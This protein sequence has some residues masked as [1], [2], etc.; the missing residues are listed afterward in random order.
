MKKTYLQM[1]GLV[2]AMG[3][4][5]A[6]PPLHAQEIGTMSER[7]LT[8]TGQGLV[9]VET[10]IATVRLGVEVSGASAEQVQAEVAQRSNSLVEELR[11]QRVERL[12]TTGIS[13]FPDYNSSSGNRPRGVRG[14]NIVQFEVPVER[15]GE[16]LDGA[17]AAGAGQIQSVTFRPTD[18]VLEAG[19]KA[20][21]ELAV[22]D[23][24]SQ[25]DIVLGT[26]D[27]QVKSIRNIQVGNNSAPP[28]IALEA[29]TLARSS[30]PTPV[31][32][33]EQTVNARVTLAIEY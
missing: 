5:L 3:T 7:V 29:A 4:C 31:I 2:L 12:Q 28:P 17:I 24:R 13:L 25:A 20:A 22:A 30:S 16:I 27:F 33:G 9:M 19:R 6:V 15:A 8:V 32:G 18:E 14:Q 1:L 21:L 26:L 11:R 10:A 23:A